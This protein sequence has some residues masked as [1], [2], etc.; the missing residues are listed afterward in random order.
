M[1]K[2]VAPVVDRF[3]ADEL[4]PGRG[5]GQAEGKRVR[6]VLF[7]ILQ[8]RGRKDHDGV[9]DGQ[10][11]QHPCALDH[12]PRIGLFLYPCGKK[13]IGLLCCADRTI[14]LG[15]DQRVSERKVALAHFPVK[16]PG[17]GATTLM[18]RVQPIG[19]GRVGAHGAI[20]IA[21]IAARHSE[22][23]F[24][25]P[26]HRV[27]DPGEILPC[28]G[29][30]EAHSHRITGFRRLKEQ[31]FGFAVLQIVTGSQAAHPVSNPLFGRYVLNLAA[32]VPQF[33]R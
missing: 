17:V 27:A 7:G 23:E 24:R 9:R 12:Q 29:N 19:A 31:S 21:G 20:Q 2:V 33:H 16:G 26:V 25:N 32:P 15:V 13:R 1:I 22:A 30:H 10:R 18:R 28:F 14:D 8:Q 4:Q 3:A 11:G 5:I 6:R